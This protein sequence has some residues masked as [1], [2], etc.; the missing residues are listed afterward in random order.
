[1]IT[2]INKSFFKRMKKLFLVYFYYAETTAMNASYTYRVYKH[3]VKQIS[4]RKL[5][6]NS[7]I[8][9]RVSHTVRSILLIIYDMISPKYCKSKFH[10]I[11]FLS[12]LAIFNKL[13][14]SRTFT[15][16]IHFNSPLQ[17]W[18]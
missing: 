15:L 13:L 10:H 16:K 6:K 5:K 7:F 11:Q 17:I 2:F 8:S 9:N 14:S 3:F 18:N 4:I 1:M 12:S